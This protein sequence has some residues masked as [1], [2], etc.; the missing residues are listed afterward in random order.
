MEEEY[1]SKKESCVY[2]H[3]VDKKGQNEKTDQKHGFAEM[4]E[5]RGRTV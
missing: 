3:E 4:K 1:F 5:E 2:G